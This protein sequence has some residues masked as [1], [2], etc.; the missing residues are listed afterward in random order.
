M[1]ATVLRKTFVTPMDEFKHHV[2][3]TVANKTLAQGVAHRCGGNHFEK[4]FCHSHV[5]ERQVRSKVAF[6]RSDNTEYFQ[7]LYKKTLKRRHSLE[8]IK[9]YSGSPKKSE[10][11]I[12]PV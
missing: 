7:T 2:P 5:E 10:A 9:R 1:V 6:R 12:A 8:R 3:L 4:N 11:N